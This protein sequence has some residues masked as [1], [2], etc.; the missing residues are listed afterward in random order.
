[1]TRNKFIYFTSGVC[2][3]WLVLSVAVFKSNSIQT[4]IKEKVV[5]VEYK[6]NSEFSQDS[7]IYKLKELNF[8]YPHI[9]LAQAQLETG[10]LKSNIFLSCHNLFGMKQAKTRITHASGTKRGHA[11]FNTWEESVYDYAFYCCR[12]MGKFT[13]EQEYYNYLA[14]NY[15]EDPKYISKVKAQAEKN[16]KYF[17]L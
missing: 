7:L 2:F 1:M 15:A 8:K 13:S 10:G 4:I 11:F 9:V 16:K 17:Q 6:T 12:Y 3:G 14:K 5:S